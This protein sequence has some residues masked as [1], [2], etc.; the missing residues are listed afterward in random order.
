MNNTKITMPDWKNGWLRF[1]NFKNI[2][3]V[4]FIIYADI[5]SLLEPRNNTYCP[6]GGKM[7][8]GTF[9]KHIANSIGYYFHSR[10]DQNLSHYKSFSG[11]DCIDQFIESLLFLMENV[12][13]PRIH[14][15]KPMSLNE[16][17]ECD[18]QNADLCHICKK[19][20]NFKWGKWDKVRDHCHLT[21]KYRGAS[22]SEC[23]LKFQI[24]KSIPVVFH[25][26][27]YDSHFLIEKLAN[28]FPGRMILIPKNSEHYISFSKEL[29]DYNEKFENGDVEKED[30]N[31]N[32]DA[33]GYDVH[34]I[35]R[36]R[37]KLRLRFIDSYRFLQCSL[38]KLAESLPSDK[39][40]ITRR[41]WANLSDSEFQLLTKKGVYPY[42]YIDSWDK[43]NETQLPAKELFYDDL[44]DC[45]ITDEQYNHAQNVWHTFGIQTLREY[46]DH[47]LKTDILLLADI[48]ENF[49]DNCINLYELDPA[50][51]YTLPGYSWDCMLKYTNVEIELLK[52][53][54]QLMFVERGLRGGISQCSNR[55]C[56][57]NNKYIG[58]DYNPEKPSNYLLY[59]DINNLYGWAMSQALPLSQFRWNTDI[60][61]SVDVFE[62]ELMNMADDAPFGFILEVDLEYPQNLHDQ[63]NDYPFCCEHM[64]VVKNE[65]KVLDPGDEKRFIVPNTYNT[66]AWGHYKIDLFKDIQSE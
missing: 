12:V 56:K 66:L 49:R 51:Y 45:E 50:H 34:V 58:A 3:E 11:P 6:D 48:F 25:N 40:N 35:K 54:D 57:A 16:E 14:V 4:P 37:E 9:Q 7:P 8:K 46:T 29:P 39:L 27:D 59:L 23:N 42:V 52:D 47:Y 44:N 5:E 1:S 65:K 17:E 24:S 63:H 41:Q 62:I 26:L 43:L 22:H 21:G 18:F 20:F 33:P 32:D 2:I 60:Y 28:V 61:A 55:Y 13:W 31:N 15:I 53:I 38:A 64:N 36:Y 30:N 19:D 10:F